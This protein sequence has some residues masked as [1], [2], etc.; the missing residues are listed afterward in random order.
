[1][2]LY[3]LLFTFPY[4]YNGSV[5]IYYND[6]GPGYV[7]NVLLIYYLACVNNSTGTCM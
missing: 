4:Y 3:T 2:Y 5:N 1:M 7:I 6:N